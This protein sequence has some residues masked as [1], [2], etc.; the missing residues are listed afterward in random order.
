MSLT[1]RCWL[2][3]VTATEDTVTPNSSVN[4]IN[5]EK[6]PKPDQNADACTVPDLGI[7]LGK[8][9]VSG[10]VTDTVYIVDSVRIKVSTDCVGATLS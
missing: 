1:C 5:M 3:S 8:D 7:L 10:S 9:F 2:K 6:C 4:V